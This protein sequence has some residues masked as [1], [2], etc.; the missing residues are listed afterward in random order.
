MTFKSTL[1]G[2]LVISLGT[3]CVGHDDHDK[4]QMPLGYIRFP[5]EAMY[6]GDNSG[7]VLLSLRAD[8]A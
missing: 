7:G 1:L 5:Y 4:D 2:L 3:S 6:P 8:N